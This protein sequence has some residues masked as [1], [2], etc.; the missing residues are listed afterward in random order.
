[1]ADILN[2]A[3]KTHYP[4]RTLIDWIDQAILI[5]RFPSKIPALRDAGLSVS[6]VD[7]AWMV[8]TKDRPS[9]RPCKPLEPVMNLDQASY[10]S[11]LALIARIE[12]WGR[13]GPGIRVT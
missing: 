13:S 8:A 2:L 4:L 12:G 1:M 3:V 11:I 9:R 10:F 6:A 5:Q 7:L